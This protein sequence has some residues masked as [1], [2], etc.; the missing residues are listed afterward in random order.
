MR[1]V[2]AEEL[3][4]RFHE[5]YEHLAPHFGYRTREASAV[6]FDQ[7]PANNRRLMIA[8]CGAILKY[9]QEEPDER[10]N[11]ALRKVLSDLMSDCDNDSWRLAVVNARA[12]LDRIPEAKP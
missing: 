10:E 9:L 2:T 1:N 11:E 3:A 12:A 4:S 7:I 5:I 6:P 8:T